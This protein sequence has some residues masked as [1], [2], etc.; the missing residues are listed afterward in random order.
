MAHFERQIVMPNR[1]FT[2][3]QQWVK[4]GEIQS[5]QHQEFIYG[6]Y[7]I[8]SYF[9]RYAK[10][11]EHGY[12]ISEIKQ[13]L[14]YSPK[15][16]KTNYIIKTNGLLDLKK[17]TKTVFD[18]PVVWKLQNEK[19]T[20]TMYSE[21]NQYER[22]RLNR[23]VTKKPFVKAPLLSIGQSNNGLFWNSEGTHIVRGEVF[24]Q[25]MNNKELGCAGLYMYGL[26]T[27]LRNIN[28]VNHKQSTFQCSNETLMSLTGWGMKKVKRVT[29]EMYHHGLIDKQQEVRAKGYV[30]WYAVH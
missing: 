22:A 21:F 16:K 6:F 30:N 9:W 23:F 20:F 8:I 24:V 14:H 25:C 11:S 2:D 1:I 7:W 19:L 5:V 29:S 27:N 28:F 3:M 17:Y 18:F 15:D 13:M 26:L 10:Y 4:R 12:S